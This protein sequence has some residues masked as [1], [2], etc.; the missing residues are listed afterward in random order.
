MKVSG[1]NPEPKNANLFVNKE[2]LRT[3]N[4][5]SSSLITFPDLY[6]QIFYR[7]RF[8]GSN[9]EIEITEYYHRLNNPKNW[10]CLIYGA[11]YKSIEPKFKIQAGVSSLITFLDL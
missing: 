5:C 3:Y 1:S 11:T 6:Y 4:T 7:V 10:G 2:V 9:T 8:T